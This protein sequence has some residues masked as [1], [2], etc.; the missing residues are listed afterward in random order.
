MKREMAMA[1]ALIGGPLVA[2]ETNT[3]VKLPADKSKFH[4]ILMVGQSNMIGRGNIDYEG[5]PIHPR[6][7]VQKKGKWEQALDP[8]ELMVDEKTGKRRGGGLGPT[9]ARAYAEAHPDVTV[10]IV[11]RAAG[12]TKIEQ[13]K[14]PDALFYKNAVL[15]TKTALKDGT[16]K[17]ILWHQ[18]ESDMAADTPAY[19]EKLQQLIADFRED[20]GLPDLPFVLGQVPAFSRN[21]SA[22]GYQR[23]IDAIARIPAQAPNTA[24][25]SAEGL[26]DNGDNLHINAESQIEFG[27]R[28]FEVY[29]TLLKEN[30]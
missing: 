19:G 25:V 28:Y 26:K 22:P 10:G 18:G 14:K 27:K 23:V 6:V 20:F 3:I 17:V 1:L 15:H 11:M 29:R 7:L 12:G 24:V 9:F 8:L 13:W 5:R 21:V 2:Q 16:L 4:I 30:R